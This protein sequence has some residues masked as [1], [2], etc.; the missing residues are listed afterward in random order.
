MKYHRPSESCTKCPLRD[1]PKVLGQGSFK[2]KVAFFGEAPGQHE[3]DSGRPFVGPA[4]KF[5]SWALG[6]AGIFRH[7]IWLSN[8]ILCRPPKNKIDSLEGQGALH[9]CKL[10]FMEEVLYLIQE[11]IKVFVPLGGTAAKAFGLDGSILKIRGSVY[12]RLLCENGKGLFFWDKAKQEKLAPSIKI[13][14]ELT[15]LPTMHPSYLMRKQYSGR[16]GRA[17]PKYIWIADLKKVQEVLQGTWQEAKEDFLTNPSLQDVENFVAYVRKEKPLLALDIETTGFSRKYAREVVIGFAPNDVQGIC[18]PVLKEKGKEYWPPEQWPKVKALVEE[19]LQGPLMLQNALFDILFL[20]RRG[21]KVQMSAVKHD[22]M[23]MH[24]TLNPEL[25]HDLGFI[26]SIYGKTAYWKDEFLNREISI[27][28]MDQKQMREYNLRDCIVLH[29]ILPELSRDLQEAGLEQIYEEEAIPL[30]DPVGEMISNGVLFDTK[31]Q[32]QLKRKY[33]KKQKEL[34]EELR[35]LVE[36]P[37][38]FN[39]DSKD[40]LRWLL[41][42]VEPAKFD[43]ISE[44]EDFKG[45]PQREIKCSV[46]KKKSWL[47][48]EATLCPKC[49]SDQIEDTGKQREK[50]KRKPGSKVHEGLLEA[51]ILKEQVKP[52][53]LPS[54]FSG[55]VTNA[56]SLSVAKDGLLSYQIALQN[57]LA[58]VLKLKTPRPEEEQEIRKAL[59]FLSL[60]HEWTQ[61]HKLARDFLSYTPEDDGRIYGSYLVH[62]TATSRLSMRDPNL[63]QVPK[64]AKDIRTMFI[65]PP[66]CSL[67]SGDYEN[68]EVHVLAHETKEP[69]LYPVIRGE[70][71]QHDEN[72]KALFHITK[73]DPMWG[74]A[75]RGAKIF[76]FGRIQYGGS[77]RTIYEKVIMEAPELGLTFAQFCEA[78]KNYFE[79]YKALQAWQEAIKLQARKTRKVSNFLGRTRV[80]MG[81][82]HDIEKQALNTPIQSGA[83]GVINR[84]MIRLQ[85]RIHKEVP[86]AKLI[87][88]IHD[89]LIYETPDEDISKVIELM[90]EEMERPLDF[91]GEQVHFPVDIEVGK[92][93]GSLVEVPREQSC[94]EKKGA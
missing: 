15:V 31:R 63:M 45:I 46:C 30:L 71:N 52:L 10:G 5:L 1:S 94:I 41:Y 17:N 76:Q 53:Y 2:K 60:Y 16:K 27:L 37:K 33:E 56:G 28:E 26:T 49:S 65:A 81:D 90:R 11:G 86:K 51:K 50:F 61:I 36:L 54:S 38:E 8:A 40:D 23:V 66:G 24:H 29:Q 80:L 7:Q 22:I 91:Y 35:T 42:H 69:E 47:P 64:K 6:E 57:R 74:P 73:E 20:Q 48:L 4:G 39:L 82:I 62:G 93:W 59:K 92:S 18:I 84:A 70:I 78:E 3:E 67:V 72:T 13:L 83:A 14:G 55:K 58:K 89:Q 88:Q 79:K 19:L 43:K 77:Q 44:L 68:L 87:L 12:H 34:E 9:K 32:A 75:R 25:P 21:Y 85:K